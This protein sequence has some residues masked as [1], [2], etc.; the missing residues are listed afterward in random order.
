MRRLLAIPLVLAG[1]LG[2][3][4]LDTQTTRPS[5]NHARAEMAFSSRQRWRSGTRSTMPGR[6]APVTMT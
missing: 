3:A 2:A 4:N 1:V 5:G 6:R